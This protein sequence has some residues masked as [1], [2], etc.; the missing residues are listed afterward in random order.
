[1][2]GHG[3]DGVEALVRSDGESRWRFLLNHSSDDAEIAL[4]E[5]GREVLAGVDVSGSIRLRPRGV[6]IVR[7]PLE[8]G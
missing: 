8:R 4:A 2:T 6:A 3:T 7:S 1:M 5:P